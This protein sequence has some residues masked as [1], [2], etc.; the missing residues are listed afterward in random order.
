MFTLL[1][2]QGW[3]INPGLQPKAA[4]QIREQQSLGI[5]RRLQ[6]LQELHSGS[7]K[8]DPSCVSLKPRTQNHGQYRVCQPFL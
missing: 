3:V 4:S 6:E 1:L 7:Q 2:E 5:P 8:K